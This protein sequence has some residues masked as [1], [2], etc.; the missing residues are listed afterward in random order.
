MHSLKTPVTRLACV[1]RDARGRWKVK[2]LERQLRLWAAYRCACATWSAAVPCH[3]KARALAAED[4]A[5]ATDGGDSDARN[6]DEP[7]TALV[8]TRAEK[9]HHSLEVMQLS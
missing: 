8:P 5:P 1:F 9:H 2:A 7:P 6:R 4:A 3:W